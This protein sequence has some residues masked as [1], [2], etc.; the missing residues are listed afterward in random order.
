MR[1]VRVYLRCNAFFFFFFF[2][3]GEKRREEREGEKR[4]EEKREPSSLGGVWIFPSSF[5]IFYSMDKRI[6]KSLLFVQ[7]SW[8]KVK[9]F[10]RWRCG[11]NRR[12]RQKRIFEEK[13]RRKAKKS[14]GNPFKKENA[15]LSSSTGTR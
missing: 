10:E 5:W 4:R 13:R 11:Q 3:R 15:V 2:E 9:N 7:S 6:T 14:F 8:K 12:R 1:G